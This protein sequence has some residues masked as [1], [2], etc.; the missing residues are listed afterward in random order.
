MLRADH[1]IAQ[2]TRHPVEL[3]RFVDREREHVGRLWLAAMLAVQSRDPRGVDEGDREMPLAHAGARR[4][5][6]A[7][8][9]NL[10]LIQVALA[11]R[12]VGEDLH[13]DRSPAHRR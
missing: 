5:K 6:A 11:E 12:A 8:A 4:R 13:F 2:L 9:P 1:D 10:R 7:Q 3:H